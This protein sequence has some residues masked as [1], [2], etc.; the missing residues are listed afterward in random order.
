M[1]TRSSINP[2]QTRHVHHPSPKSCPVTPRPNPKPTSLLP[3]HSSVT[4]VQG[5]AVRHAGAS[6]PPALPPDPS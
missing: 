6:C 4:N 1:V 5:A 2:L 3:Q